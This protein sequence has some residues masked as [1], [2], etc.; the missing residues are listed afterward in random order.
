MG[1]R[2]LKLVVAFV[3]VA[4]VNGISFRETDAAQLAQGTPPQAPAANQPA[5][6][7][8][9]E[10]TKESGPGWALNCKSGATDKGLECRLSQTVVTQ[11]RQLLANVT[12][13]V[14]TDKTATELIVQLPLG[15][16]LPGGTTVKVDEGTSQ[17]LNFRACDRNGCY[18]MAPVS[19][20]LLQ[21]MRNGERLLV[22]FQNL[23]QKPID[24]P[25]S[26]DGFDEA[27]AKIDG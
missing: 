13:R 21:T 25:L 5:A 14:P 7:A 22:S 11:A 26:L 4:T 1:R 27:Y 15:L 16:Y 6:S 20:T 17:R 19:S 24:V 12:V 18:A 9:P 8:K 3:L 10:P 2:F 23:E